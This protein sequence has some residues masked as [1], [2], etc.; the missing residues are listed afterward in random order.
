MTPEERFDR[1]ESNLERATERLDRL[2]Q[3]MDAF[4]VEFE[5]SQHAADLR[6][7]QLVN[8]Q[9]VLME[10]QND[11]WRAIDRLTENVDK[12]IRGRG[13]NGHEG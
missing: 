3:R 13:P 1:I 10:S 7:T 6:Y 2:T 9:T 8:M 11:T 5:K 4:D 12:L